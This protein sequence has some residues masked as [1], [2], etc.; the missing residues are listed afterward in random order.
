LG[1][2]LVHYDG[3]TAA[4]NEWVPAERVRLPR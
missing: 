1:L 3:Y 4:D 2:L